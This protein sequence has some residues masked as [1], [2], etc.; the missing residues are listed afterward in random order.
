MKW[1]C[2]IEL[3]DNAS[4]ITFLDAIAQAGRDESKWKRLHSLPERMARTDLTDKCGSC[5]HFCLWHD[6]DVN[7]CC[8]AGHAWGQRTR[9]M[10]KDYERKEE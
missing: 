1:R 2:E 5:K 4:T 6:S 10:C 3:P 9:P 7:G 8:K